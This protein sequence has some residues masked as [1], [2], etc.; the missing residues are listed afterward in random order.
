MTICKNVMRKWAIM[1]WIFR[2]GWDYDSLARRRYFSQLSP[3]ALKNMYPP[4]LPLR[5][6]TAAVPFLKL[7]GHFSLSG[8]TDDDWMALCGFLRRAW[9]E[10]ARVVQ[11]IILA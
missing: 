1:S 10:R 6:S 8:V 3:G 5:T 4:C 7:L 2:R 11:E 9:F